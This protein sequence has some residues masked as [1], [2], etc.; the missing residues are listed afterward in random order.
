MDRT[1]IS[2]EIGQQNSGGSFVLP[3]EL[4]LAIEF[5]PKP[6]ASC[7]SHQIDTSQT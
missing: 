7:E 4:G 6:G 3:P 5:R 2:S 1:M